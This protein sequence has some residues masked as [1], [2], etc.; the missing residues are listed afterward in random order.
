V[1]EASVEGCV[2]SVNEVL[3]LALKEAE[4]PDKTGDAVSDG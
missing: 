2:P 4:S 3:G 1:V